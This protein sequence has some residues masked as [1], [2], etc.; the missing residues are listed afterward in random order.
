MNAYTN[1]QVSDMTVKQV[2]ENFSLSSKQNGWRY[3]FIAKTACESGKQDELFV[4]PKRRAESDKPKADKPKA[5]KPN[6]IKLDAKT[7]LVLKL[8]CMN[9]SVDFTIDNVKNLLESTVPAET[10]MLTAEQLDNAKQWAGVETTEQRIKAY[11]KSLFEAVNNLALALDMREV[12]IARNIAVDSGEQS[13]IA[14]FK[15]LSEIVL[16]DDE[17]AGICIL[18]DDSDCF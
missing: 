17:I 8:T 4:A 15:R 5:D 11:E 3:N 9:A 13:I 16:T 14:I 18:S 7:E 1:K 2:V 10:A 6:S 12:L